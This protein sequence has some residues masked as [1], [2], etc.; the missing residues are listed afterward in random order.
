M[1]ESSIGGGKERNFGWERGGRSSVYHLGE[2]KLVYASK[3]T[4]EKGRERREKGGGARLGIDASTRESLNVFSFFLLF[5]NQID[6]PG[7]SYLNSL[8]GPTSAQD[9][10]YQ[11]VAQVRF[12]LALSLCRVSSDRC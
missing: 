8:T 12:S 5:L 1:N 3:G 11:T 4:S 7:Y 10:N 2:G 6:I 9:W